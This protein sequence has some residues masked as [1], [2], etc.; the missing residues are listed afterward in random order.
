MPE[1]ARTQTENGRVNGRRTAARC[2]DELAQRAERTIL[3]INV[4]NT[5]ENNAKRKTPLEQ[6]KEPNRR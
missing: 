6:S 1:N 3:L 5:I 4:E 2:F